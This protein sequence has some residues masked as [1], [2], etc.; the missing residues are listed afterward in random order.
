MDTVFLRSGRTDCILGT[1]VLDSTNKI[2]GY[3]GVLDSAA[4][5]T[6]SIAGNVLTVTVLTSGGLWPGNV[7][8]GTNLLYGTYIKEQLTGTAHGVGTYLV[9]N[10]QTFASGALTAIASGLPKYKDSPYTTFQAVVIGSGTVT[11]TIVIECSNDG[12]YWCSTPLGT[13]VLSGTTFNSDGFIT[14][15]PWKY[16]RAK[17][18]AISGTSA[19]VYV[20]MGI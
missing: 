19:A 12:L 13:I 6:G 8:S 4:S 7:L 15:A 10:S 20:V 5:V 18:T 3:L 1:N 14:Q 9:S 16:V 17:V 2:T 11:A